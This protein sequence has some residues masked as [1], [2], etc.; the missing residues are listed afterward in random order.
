MDTSFIRV[1]GVSLELM[2]VKESIIWGCE[3]SIL[4]GCFQVLFIYLFIFDI[5]L[6]LVID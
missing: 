2:S 6:L 3:H 5:V 4:L 1:G